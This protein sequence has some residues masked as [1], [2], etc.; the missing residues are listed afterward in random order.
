[1]IIAKDLRRE[2]KNW[3]GSLEP[4][5]FV[6]HNF[7]FLIS[8]ETGERSLKRF[9]NRLQSQV[10]GQNWNR[11][12]TDQ[13]MVAVGFWEHLDSNPHCHV[14]V[15]ASDAESARLFE[16]GNKSWLWLQPRGQFDIREIE[17]PRKAISYITKEIYKPDSQDQLFVYKAPPSNSANSN[18]V[19]PTSNRIDLAA[20]HRHLLPD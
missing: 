6:T 3:F 13:P 11:R 19:E 20:V 8:P 9:Y 10:H 17:A 18:S 4:Q 5:L 16:E 1:M 14:L 15:S 7:G 2:V 12:D